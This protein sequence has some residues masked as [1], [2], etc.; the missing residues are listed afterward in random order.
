MNM[1]VFS[2]KKTDISKGDQGTEG[3]LED[4]LS[5][6]PPEINPQIPEFPRTQS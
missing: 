4:P 3:S 6:Y 2:T 1:I 5:H